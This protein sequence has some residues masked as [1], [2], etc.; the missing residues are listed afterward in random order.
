M[1][2]I[3]FLVGMLPN[4]RNQKRL[5]LESTLAEVH[6]ICWDRGRNMV[7]LSVP[8]GVRLHRLCIDA[9][10]D[11][12]GNPLKRLLPFRRFFVQAAKLLSEIQPDLIHAENLDMLC[13]ALYAKRKSKKAVKILYEI[14]DLHS[15]VVDNQRNL[16]KKGIQLGLHSMDT[17]LCRKVDLLI[18]TSP[19][20]YEVYYHR[21]IPREKMMYIPNA[22]EEAAFSGYSPKAPGTPFTVGFIGQVFYKQQALNLVEAAKRAG[23]H[24]LIAGYETDGQGEVEAACRGYAQGEWFGRFDFRTQAAA[25]YGKCDAIH[26]V[27][28]ADMNNVKNLLPN[29]LYE[30]VRCR[31]PVI[32]AKDTY[33]SRIV[34]EW[35]VGLSVD[36]RSVEELVQAIERLRSEPGLYNALAENCGKHRKDTDLRDYHQCLAARLVQLL[37]VPGE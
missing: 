12:A 29:K 24:L 32:V 18:V 36:H 1:K 23:I 17:L 7:A 3:A 21:L 37:E 20:F 25:L 34:E 2:K 10:P 35:G 13:I 26:L 19:L 28:N 5:A 33:L 27:Y 4:P 16:L 30:A 6:L 14:P 11:M 8:E 31:L 9:D 22:P 15:L